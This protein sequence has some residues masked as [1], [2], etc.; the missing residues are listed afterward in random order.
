[1]NNSHRPGGRRK[2]DCT[3][4]QQY[5]SQG[6]CAVNVRIKSERERLL[7]YLVAFVQQTSA[8]VRTEE[9]SSSGY[10]NS[11]ERSSLS[12]VE[13]SREI[14]LR[15]HV[16][17]VL[18]LCL[19]VP[20]LMMWEKKNAL[21]HLTTDEKKRGVIRYG[22]STIYGRLLPRGRW[23]STT[24]TL[25]PPPGKFEHVRESTFSQTLDFVDL[26][27]DEQER[28]RYQM[29]TNEQ[30]V[31]FCAHA[32]RNVLWSLLPPPPRCLACRVSIS[33]SVVQVQLH[34]RQ[35]ERS[36]ARDSRETDG[37]AVSQANDCRGQTKA[38]VDHR[39]HLQGQGDTVDM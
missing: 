21:A 6:E 33:A 4:P 22:G 24:T 25:P 36:E 11:Q 30:Q 12:L 31:C 18:C 19:F 27:C 7:L 8:E 16:H 32:G 17:G 29:N 20:A 10:E 38:S 23:A 5:E 2:T 13:L 39:G 26:C 14:V 28:A 34:T 9:T 15:R 3:R 35:R 1:M 37:P